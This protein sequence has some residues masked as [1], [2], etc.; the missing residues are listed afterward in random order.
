MSERD[1][2]IL[3]AGDALITRPW[4]HIA[5]PSFLQLVDEIRAA[6]VSITNLETVIHEFRGYAQHNCGGTYMA[7]PPLIATELKWAGFDMVAHANNHTFDYGS[8][9][10]LETIEHVEKS[11]L[12]LAGSGVDLQQAR[13][14]RYFRS[15]GVVI[16]L[17]AMA[18]SFISYGQASRSRLDMRGRPGLNPLSLTSRHKAIVVPPGAAARMRALGRFLGRDPRE[19]EDRSFKIGLRFHVGRHFGLERSQ[20]LSTSHRSANLEAISLATRDADIVVVSIHAHFQGRWLREFAMD[21]IDL[22]AA[23]VF[24][25]GPHAVRGIEAY[26]GKPIFYS[27]GDFVFEIESIEKFPAEAYE[28][29]GLGEST[30]AGE[31]KAV[32]KSLFK[33]LSRRSAFEGVAAVVRIAEGRASAVRLLPLDLQFDSTE[34]DRGRPRMASPEVGKRIIEAIAARSKAHGTSVQYDAAANCGYVAL[35]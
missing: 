26:R 24:I 19:L 28:R 11:G 30:S 22:G 6:D 13:A 23:I 33:H 17:V 1:V 31:F 4:S 12:A 5:E 29:A 34:Q 8:E 18:A 20:E 14:P 25:H 2:S 32:Q 35:S 21:A 27:L 3:F 10:V 16:G 7:S 15:K 9:G